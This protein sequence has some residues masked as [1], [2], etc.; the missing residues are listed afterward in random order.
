MSN[1][2]DYIHKVLITHEEIVAYCKQLAHDIEAQYEGKQLTLVCILKGSVPFL[3][4]L[5]QHFTR[6]DVI[7]EYIRVSSYEGETTETA[8]K[9]NITHATFDSL[10][11]QHVIIV[12]DI[13]D[14]GLTI[15]AVYKMLEMTGAESIKVATL[16]DKSERRRIDWE[17][18]F[19]GFAIPNHF[20]IGFGL[21]YNEKYR[22]LSDIV[23]PNPEKL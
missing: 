3:A 6:P 19:V 15:D 17:P 10:A 4:E 2:Q 9:V 23:I 5:S 13:I 21:D 11:G 14:T 12:E 1:K 20:V 22:N 16:L 7:F 18:D 8:G